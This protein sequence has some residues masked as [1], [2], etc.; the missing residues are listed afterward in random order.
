LEL[1]DQEA[2][3]SGEQALA[4]KLAVTLKSSNL[5]LGVIDGTLDECLRR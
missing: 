4:G 1:L 2:L 3:V 5:F